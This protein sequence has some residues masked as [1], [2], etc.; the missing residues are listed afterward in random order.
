[1]NLMNLPS[2]C[3]QTGKREGIEGCVLTLMSL[4]DASIEEFLRIKF[5]V[6]EFS[7]TPNFTLT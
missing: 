2:V 7:M 1:M 3:W 5:S 6:H 4:P